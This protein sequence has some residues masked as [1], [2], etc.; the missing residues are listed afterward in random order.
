LLHFIT[1]RGD[2]MKNFKNLSRILGTVFLAIILFS[3]SLLL[4]IS[5][6]NKSFAQE[7]SDA[8]SGTR[9]PSK[10]PSHVLEK[11]QNKGIA[12]AQQSTST[13]NKMKLII[14][15]D[16][17]SQ[18]RI[19]TL[20]SYGI[21]VE[22]T[23][24]NQV[25]AS[26]PYST[27]V[28]ISELSFVEFIREPIF[29]FPDVTSEGAA[30]INADTVNLAGI[31][32]SGVNVAV[33]DSGF[34]ITDAEISGNII[35]SISFRSDTLIAGGSTADRDHGTATAQIVVDVAPDVN[36]HL[37]NFET[38]IEF[39]NLVDFLINNRSIDVITMSLAFFNAGWYDGSSQISQK[40][41]EARNDGI[42][43]TNSAGNY[44]ERH[45]D[46]QF[47]DTDS[48][49]F[50]NFA[51]VDETI[52][53]SATSGDVLVAFLTWDDWAS[54][55]QDFD[56]ELRDNSLTLLA[57]SVNDQ[58]IGLP[59]EESIAFV[60]PSTG[61]YH[62]DIVEFSSTQNVD[63]ELFVPFHDLDEYNV[64]SSSIPNA[65]D[66]VGA[67]VVGAVNFNDSQLESFSSRGPT[68]DARTK[69][70]LVGPD[71]VTTSSLNPFF[72]TS[73]S[74]PHVAGAAALVKDAIPGAS[75]DTIQQLLEQNTFN[76]HAKNNNDGTGRVDVSFLL[77]GGCPTCVDFNND[78]YDDLAVGVPGEN[79]N[80]GAVH[81]I[82]GSTNG[83]HQW[84]G[85]TNQLWTQNS[86]GMFDSVEANDNF[87]GSGAVG[88]FNNDGYDDLAV[89]VNNEDGTGAVH[90]IYGS[91]N[92]LHQWLG[93][94]NQLWTQNSPGMFDSA[95]TFDNFGGSG[96][97]GDFNNDG[98]DDLAVGVSSEN[99]GGGVHA[100]Y[101]SANGLHQWLGRTNQ[102]WTQDS[103][104]IFD[105]TE[106]NDQFGGS[107]AVGDFNNDG[108]DD[109]AVG[110]FVEDNTGAVNVIYGSAN[111]LHQWLGRTN[112]LWTQN[113]PGM[114][115]SA[116]A[117]D[118]FGREVAVGDFNND[119]YDDLAV[120]IPGEDDTGAVHVIYGSANGLHQWLGRT[121]QL[122]T[123]NSPGMFDSAETFDSFGRSVAVGDFNN[124]GYDDL[125]VG[126]P[127][128]NSNSGATH[129]IYGSANGLHQWLG[130]TNQLW[131]QNSPGMFDS[132]EAGDFFGQTVT[133]GD[134][135]N[136]GYDDLGIGI[137]DENGTGA[138]HVIYGSANGLHQWL[139][140][141]NQ[142][143][144]QNS[145]GMFDS[146][147]T[148]DDF[149]I[150]P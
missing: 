66:A 27:I 134:F 102:L 132:A 55:S 33:I 22:T 51:G 52:N 144:T 54:P 8:D 7:L 3:T 83:L 68:N 34:D 90:V 20:K 133:V 148:G 122:W 135:N 81:A 64:A 103:P 41:T 112:Q 79:S 84:L 128:E 145:P 9:T 86:P 42:L 124:D 16:N 39:L 35:E 95:E 38:G 105:S 12:Q 62:L 29:A 44:A 23:H 108:Y 99:G 60:I 32:G 56:L 106:L 36:L 71:R 140:R 136:D 4:L 21:D 58:T 45:W 80:T 98:Y 141:T 114:F 147:E 149:Y 50:H 111:G 125:A 100:I 87:G 15:L 117:G 129:V 67:F 46:G 101:G 82:Y 75:A 113:S 28:D 31:T 142:L 48:D 131:T 26:I 70:D 14:H 93:R 85:R 126:I 63:F 10:I 37:Y 146:A 19:D 5:E 118:L 143:W 130:R 74:A 121:N 11:I 76:N 92:G 139:G 88:N 94:T 97:V 17:F 61:T 57:F 1:G 89:G 69:P 137:A 138:V 18:D 96:A 25:Q 78:G 119:G 2:K 127:G 120:G 116:E 107:V 115:D 73:A 65:G 91:A 110:A 150:L 123:Q 24:K 6:N 77:T 53:I 40:I 49:G 59:P 109:L 72:G 30:F 13:E 43:W 104:G 47:S